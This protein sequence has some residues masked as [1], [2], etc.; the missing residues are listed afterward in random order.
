MRSTHLTWTSVLLMPVM[1]D[2]GARL[3]NASAGVKPPRISFSTCHLSLSPKRDSDDV[4]RPSAHVL[5]YSTTAES[6][7]KRPTKYESF[8]FPRAFVSSRKPHTTDPITHT[9][10][11]NS[12]ERVPHSPSIWGELSALVDMNRSPETIASFLNICFD[13]TC[14][15]PVNR[16]PLYDWHHSVDLYIAGVIH[17]NSQYY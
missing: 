16:R 4:P 12:C 11:E 14:L 17:P 9:T 3:S 1:S 8:P 6:F 5:S 13:M 2:I 7:S 15:W 10:S